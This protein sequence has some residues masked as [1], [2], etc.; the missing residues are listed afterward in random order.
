LNIGIDIRLLE[1]HHRYRG[2]GVYLESILNNLAL[3]D[4]RNQYYL[5]TS[6]SRQALKL[7]LPRSFNYKL[8]SVGPLPANSSQRLK[9]VF[10]PL[11]WDS[12]TY[13]IDVFLQPEL[14]N[15]FPRGRVKKISVLYDLIPILYKDRYYPKKPL[16]KSWL[17][18]K[19]LLLAYRH[20]L[21]GYKKLDA[22]IAISKSSRD[23]LVSYDQAIDTHK[24]S[25]IPL[26]VE[27][28]RQAGREP[29][30][31]DKLTRPF[32]LY[33][34]S[35]DYRKN[36]VDIIKAFQLFRL[37]GNDGVLVLVG[38]DFK[39]AMPEELK[40]TIDKSAYKQDIM[41][42]GFVDS[43]A[44]NWLYAHAAAFLFA[45]LYEGFGMP[46]LEAIS[47]SCPVISYRNSSLPEV[48]DDAVLW[49][50]DANSMATY[51]IKLQ[52]DSKL[53]KVMVND[54]RRQA[55]KFTWGKTAKETL[56]LVERLHG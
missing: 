42:P 34:G 54:G 45:S 44:L 20:Q 6:D 12:E 13:E 33:V 8:I 3:V 29:G 7:K 11:A 26:G 55:L 48:L 4:N 50:H 19:L 9:A 56:A 18:Q 2:I 23:D 39:D 14:A 31:S 21:K 10:R 15:G 17:V 51:M 37:V 32:F 47:H 28:T 30:F 41:L 49:A 16:G 5:F 53:R 25:V 52:G 46:P 40:E 24:I 22:V 43:Q 35:C 1:S 38:R 36:V 27:T